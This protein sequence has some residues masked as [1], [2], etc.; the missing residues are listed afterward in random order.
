MSQIHQMFAGQAHAEQVIA[1]AKEGSPTPMQLNR[2]LFY[3]HLYAG[4]YCEASGKNE[5]AMT[6]LSEAV[7]HEVPD[8]MY[9][10]GR[11]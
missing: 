2:Q 5:D 4:S 9:G 10:V 6:H 11:G 1:A 8:Y 3:A 7:K